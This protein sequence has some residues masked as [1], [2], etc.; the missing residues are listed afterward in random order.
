MTET[1]LAKLGSV[2]LI[3]VD[4]IKPNSQQPRKEFDEG[5]LRD[6]AESIKQ[7]GVLQPL[8]V[9]RKETTTDR[10]IQVDYE[11]IAGERRLRASKLAG[12]AQVPVVIRRETDEKIKLELAIIENLQR[13]DLNPLDRA[14]AFKK[15]IDNFSLKHYEVA[16][17]VGKSREYVSNS[18]R[19]LA[20]PEEIKNGLVKGELS[21]GHC[22]AL[23]MIDDNPDKQ[24]KLYKE[25]VDRKISVRQAEKASRIIID[26]GKEPSE[27]IGVMPE[28]REIEKKLSDTLGTK[29]HV[30]LL[31]DK[32][33]IS[34]NFF[35]GNELNAFINKII[36]DR[37]EGAAWRPTVFTDNDDVASEQNTLPPENLDT[38]AQDQINP[39]VPEDENLNQSAGE[40]V[41]PLSAPP[42]PILE[43]PSSEDLIKNFSI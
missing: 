41:L 39:Q 4:K 29:V 35:S 30:E 2:F 16:A 23:L 37:A 43:Q 28:I 31:R 11:L 9:T 40:S 10:G 22:R 18:I 21:E 13:E 26:E 42:E 12:L 25:I 17:R 15:L 6:L 27:A 24:M 7:Y 14:E 1:E 8:V 36:N 20:L 38:V 32:G 33:K 5:K 34:I 3:E 19:L